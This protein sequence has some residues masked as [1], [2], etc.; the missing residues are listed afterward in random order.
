MIYKS[1]LTDAFLDF[2]DK[3]FAET[4]DC[5]VLL[6]LER[7]IQFTMDQSYA[8]APAY[9]YFLTKLLEYEC[10]ESYKV[11]MELISSMPNYFKYEKT[12]EMVYTCCIL[13]LYVIFR[14]RKY[15]K[16]R[17]RRIRIRGFHHGML[18]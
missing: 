17:E 13:L 12:K 9:E 10:L 1:D 3:I 14:N 7:R 11:D 15:G 6:S 16:L 4:Q 2:V 5:L 18:R 8:C